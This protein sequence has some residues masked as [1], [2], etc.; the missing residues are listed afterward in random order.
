MSN[1]LGLSRMKHVE[2]LLED[3]MG[4]REEAA[5]IQRKIYSKCLT[6]ISKALKNLKVSEGLEQQTIHIIHAWMKLCRYRKNWLYW[7]NCRMNSVL[8][9]SESSNQKLIHATFKEIEKQLVARW[10]TSDIN[11]QNTRSTVPLGQHFNHECNVSLF[12]QKSPIIERPSS[13]N[14]GAD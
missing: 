4:S 1:P 2:T 9:A 12:L 10:D 3:F 8:Q 7:D 5:T 13:E 14:R 11:D 6:D